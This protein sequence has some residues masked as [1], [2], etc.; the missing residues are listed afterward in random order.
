MH[1]G[2]AEALWGVDQ[3]FLLGLLP[4]LERLHTLAPDGAARAH[5]DTLLERER[6]AQREMRA[7]FSHF[8]QCQ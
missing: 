3:E 8:V 7:H 2:G 5:L 6:G 1:R 4:N